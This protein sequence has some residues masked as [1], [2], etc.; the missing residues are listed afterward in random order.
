[1]LCKLRRSF[2]FTLLTFVRPPSTFVAAASFSYISRRLSNDADLLFSQLARARASVLSRSRSGKRRTWS[3]ANTH[4]LFNWKSV[5]VKP[6]CALLADVAGHG[7]HR[8][9]HIHLASWLS[10]PMEFD[11][12]DTVQFK[13]CA[14]DIIIGCMQTTNGPI[15]KLKS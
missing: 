8:R 15:A 3:S 2:G 5:S 7:E 1:M 14:N 13:Q 12:I 10:D 9:R 4:W 11:I 6:K